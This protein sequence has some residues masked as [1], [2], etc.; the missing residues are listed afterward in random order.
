MYSFKPV[1]KLESQ[2]SKDENRSDKHQEREKRHKSSPFEW[3]WSN[4][5][6]GYKIMFLK[7]NGPGKVKNKVQSEINEY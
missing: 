2:G 3:S 1:P 5:L 6:F 7:L 4:P